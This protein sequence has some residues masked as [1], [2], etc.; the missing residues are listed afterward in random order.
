MAYLKRRIGNIFLSFLWII[1]QKRNSGLIGRSGKLDTTIGC[2]Q[3][4]CAA[5][6]DGPWHQRS[7]SLIFHSLLPYAE[8]WLPEI[9]KRTIRSR[10]NPS[11]RRMYTVAGEVIKLKRFGNECSGTTNVLG[12]SLIFQ[13]ATDCANRLQEIFADE[14]L[15]F[16]DL[17]TKPK[18]VIANANIGVSC[19]YFAELYP[20]AQ[21]LAFEPDPN[22]FQILTTNI[23][24]FDAKNIEA[25]NADLWNSTRETS[26][27]M[28]ERSLDIDGEKS[29]PQAATHYL[30]ELFSSR[31]DFLQ[32]DLTNKEIDR[33]EK[34]EN[35]LHNI[36]RIH[37]KFYVDFGG[38]Q[39]LH[40][41]TGLFHKTGFRLHV[42]NQNPA[43][44]PFMYRPISSGCDSILDVFAIRE[45]H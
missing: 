9:A 35:Q 45:A 12:K 17:H 22:L 42:K 5:P 36:Q 30:H 39:E 4:S 11:Q 33:L 1:H 19:I 21:I 16:Q 29:D 37:A 44:Q 27:R 38:Q 20:E 14:Q 8:D 10:L 32:L 18:I 13:S 25:C 6:L 26:T 24:E 23:D 31:I 41:M 3:V 43:Q 40:R 7:K 2:L 15:K 28:K 34:Y